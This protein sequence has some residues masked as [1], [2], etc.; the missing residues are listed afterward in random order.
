MTKV[1]TTRGGGASCRPIVAQ[2]CEHM[3]RTLRAAVRC[4]E[5]DYQRCDRLGLLVH[6]RQVYR[7][8]ER[9]Y[10]ALTPSEESDAER[11][12]EE[13]WSEHEGR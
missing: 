5:R 12:A 4:R 2:G 1:Y 11:F 9:G 8:T 6:P 10:E 7:V 3:H 13:F